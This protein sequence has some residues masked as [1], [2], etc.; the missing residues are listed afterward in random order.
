VKAIT[1]EIDRELVTSKNRGFLIA[2][3]GHI[4]NTGAKK[5]S[6]KAI[7]QISRDACIKAGVTFEKA[8]IWL[9]IM[10]EKANH[11]SDAINTIDILCDGLKK[12]IG[13]DDRWFSIARL[14]WCLVKDRRPV[15]RV[16]V[17]QEQD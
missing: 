17:F 4:Y 10:V 5:T 8:K 3:A 14:D 12:G 16:R 9:D 1:V 7:E 15:V 6:L 11:R 13:I 2:R